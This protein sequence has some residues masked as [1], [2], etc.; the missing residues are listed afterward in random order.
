MKYTTNSHHI[1]L[2]GFLGEGDSVPQ[3]TESNSKD[4]AGLHGAGAVSGV[5]LQH[6][7][8]AAFFLLQDLQSFGRVAWRDYSV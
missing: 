6:A 7:V 1:R 5:H 4:G 2:E 8:F 3:L